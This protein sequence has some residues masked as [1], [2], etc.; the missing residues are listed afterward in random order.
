[1]AKGIASGMPLG[2]T[3]TKA[4]I[5]DWVPGSHASTFGGNPVCLAA[6]LATFDVIEREGMKNAQTVG[7]FMMR[8]MKTW[9]EKHHMVGDVR[10][11]GLMIAVEIVKDKDLKTTAG[12]ERDRII[13]LAFERGVLL[14]GCGET[15]I[16]LSPPLI[17]TQEQAET[18]MD[19]LEECINIVEQATPANKS[20]TLVGVSGQPVGS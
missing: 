2:I 4:D 5:M 9:P 15:S 10:G 13:E 18:A 19:V 6:A 3:M 17:I 14:L 8:R 20:H 7:D 16:R 11:R 1:M 12:P